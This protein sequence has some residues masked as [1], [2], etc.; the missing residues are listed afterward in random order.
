[1]LENKTK[2]IVA[3]WKMF[4]NFEFTIH[5]FKHLCDEVIDE[6]LKIIV[7]P[8]L[9]YINVAYRILIENE[10]EQITL[11]AQNIS[12]LTDTA[13]TGEINAQMLEE[14][15]AKF[16]F[17]G[18]S[19]RRKLGETEEIINE[20]MKIINTSTLCPILCIGED[21]KTKENSKTAEFI[22]NQLETALTGIEKIENLI[23]AYEPV[24]SIGTGK[25]PTD[26]EI[27]EIANIIR[28]TIQQLTKVENLY[29]L[30]GGSIN[31]S[32]IKDFLKIKELDGVLVGGYS[33][34]THEFCETLAHISL[35]ELQ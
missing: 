17:V 28:K 8:P 1:M 20:K 32:N 24:W 27:I 29:V 15:G 3:N 7:C 22:E 4:G 18:H 5:Y 9:P 19:E 25:T 26:N 21:I 11:G 2:L 6:D 12:H 23:I 30:Y 16:V 33:L 13:S 35:A 31:G 14:S 34:K 10:N